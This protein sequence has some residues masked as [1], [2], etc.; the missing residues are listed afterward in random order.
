MNL[1]TIREQIDRKDSQII[2]LLN[3]R[4]ELALLSKKFKTSIEDNGREKEII[5]GI[6]SKTRGLIDPEFCA[7]LFKEIIT[8]S[9][10]LQKIEYRLL[11]FGGEHG[12]N[13]AAAAHQWDESMIPMPAPSFSA[14]FEGV[15]EGVYDNGI[16]PI[17]N[18]LGGVVEENN[19]LLIRN[20]LYI[21]GALDLPIHYC[22]M[23]IPG[24]DHREIRQVYSHPQALSQ[25]RE[26]IA[27]NNI[28]PVQYSNTAAA[29]KM[30]SEK[31]IKGA[32]VIAPHLAAELYGLEIVKE[33]IEDLETNRT[34]FVVIGTKPFEG[35]GTKCSVLFSTEHKSGTLFSVLEAFASQDINLTRIESVPSKPGSYV[36]FLDFVGS[37]KDPKIKNILKKLPEITSEYRFLGCYNERAVQ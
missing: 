1:K 13:G 18:S 21:V 31:S 14:V 23:V 17:E 7:T 12:S 29:A 27:R 8:E 16:V 26:F 32:A 33:N 20:N 34:R 6:M 9:K 24:T 25:C 3:D 4:M 15:T 36:F 30:L 11:A 5:D 19:N 2:T 35:E 28:E 10:R 22:L 37:E